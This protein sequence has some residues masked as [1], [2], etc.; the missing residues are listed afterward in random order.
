MSPFSL[1]TALLRSTM[2]VGAVAFAV[3]SLAQVTPGT[4]AAGNATPGAAAENAPNPEGEREITV[5]GSLIKQPQPRPRDAGHR[6]DVARRSSSAS[7]TSPKTS[8]AR[9]PASS[10]R[11]AARSTTATAVRRSSTFAASARTATSSC[12]T[13]TASC[14][15]ASRGV[16]DLNNIPLALIDRVESLT[17]AASTTYGA[18]A[19]SGVVNFITK[20][21][22]TGV[23][24]S[25]SEQITEKGDG[26]YYRVDAT[27]GGNFADDK[28]NAV[29]SVG[30]QHAD[31]VYQGDRKFSIHER[32]LV[33]RRRQRLGHVRARRASPVRATSTRRPVSRASSPV[34]R[35][36]TRSPASPS[37]T[38]WA[39]TTPGSV[40]SIPATGQAVNVV[41]AVQLQ[42]VQHLPDAVQA[43]QHLRSGELRG[44]RAL[45]LLHARP[46][47]QE[48]GRHDHRAVGR[49]R[50]G[51]HDPAQQPVPAR[52]AAQPVLRVERRAGYAQPGRSERCDC[53]DDVCAAL[54][55]GA[56]RRCRNGDEPDRSQLPHRDD[57]RSRRT[58]GV[59]SAD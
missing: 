21:N 51:G 35:A 17:G 31:P 6:H 13:A 56:V 52:R 5:T 45:R 58:T 27:I 2:L 38:R 3:P 46:V 1:K 53:P 9:S 44:E 14:L 26:N 28:G 32:Q 16:V 42:S 57:E 19:I 25:G 22:F 23:D 47:L 8:C 4:P 49:V 7:R 33:H 18:D 30:Y 34:S 15:P 40:R 11:S 36:T 48:H 59:R 37:R 55:A 12:S 43:L 29:L 39:R 54:H 10:R 41:R 24:I 20:K 50:L